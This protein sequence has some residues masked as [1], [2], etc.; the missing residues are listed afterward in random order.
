MSKSTSVTSPPVDSSRTRDIQAE[1][2]YRELLKTQQ[3]LSYDTGKM[4]ESYGLSTQ[5]FN[6][7]RILYVRRGEENGVLCQTIRKQL[8]HRDPDVSRLVER[9]REKGMVTRERCPEDRRCTKVFLT[10]EG[11]TSCEEIGE[12][13]KELLT[14]QFKHFDSD[15][16]NTLESLLVKVREPHTPGD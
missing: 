5:Q 6:L 10:D 1:Q 2:V 13:L 16:M 7:L 14:D 15:Q 3:I 12:A 4:V 8:V 11:K 9:M